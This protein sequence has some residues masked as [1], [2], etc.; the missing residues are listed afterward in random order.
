V[1]AAAAAILSFT[2]TP[3]FADRCT[4]NAQGAWTCANNA[5]T[6]SF[7]HSGSNKTRTVFWQVPEGTPPAGGWPV[8]FFYSGWDPRVGFLGIV[9]PPPLNPFTLP[10]STDN[11]AGLLPQMFHEL[12]DDPQGTGKKYAVI[13]A[14]PQFRILLGRYWDTNEAGNYANQQDFAFFPDLFGEIKSGSYGPAS[15]FNMSKRF[16]FGISSGGYNSSRMA[17]TFNQAPGDLNTWKT[18]GI[19]SASYATCR[20]ATCLVPDLPG[21]HPSV[22]FWHGI[23]DSV[24]PIWTAE[25]YRDEL[26]AD[27]KTTAF[28]DHMSGHDFDASELGSTGVKA[29]FDQHN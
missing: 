27:G 26:E 15:Q 10:T 11:N 21:N 5:R 18:L 22:K 6:H 1:A 23:N 2:S 25:L 4:Q 3:A 19:L 8:V 9:A 29:W 14:T 12:L 7:V 24:N 28:Q 20:G 13:A 17:V 16:A